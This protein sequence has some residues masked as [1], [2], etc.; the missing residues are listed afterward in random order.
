MPKI[1]LLL[2]FGCLFVVRI[3]RKR[4]S[5]GSWRMSNPSLS[6]PVS[7]DSFITDSPTNGSVSE[8][9][10]AVDAGCSNGFWRQAALVVPSALLLL[11]LGFLARRHVKKLSHRKS[12]VMIAYYAL[13]WTSAISNF[14]WSLLQGWQCSPGMAV[15]WNLLSLFTE[16]GILFLEISIVAFLLQDD[17]ASGLESLAHTFLPSG[18]FVAADILIQ[19]ILTFGFGFPLFVDTAGGGKDWEKWGFPFVH[20]LIVTAIY[21]YILFVHYSKWRDKLPP[22]PSFYN[23]AV[24]MLVFSF[25][26]LLAGGLASVGFGF[27]VWLYNFGVICR[28]ALY[29]PYLYAT[30]LADFFQEE[31][32]LLDNAYY[33]EMK[34]AG[35]FDT[36][37]E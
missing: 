3:D 5:S 12:Y 30:F 2:F 6:L 26:A 9:Y 24:V 13:L 7:P 25:A 16:S 4:F 34:D 35:F 10:D 19:A 17:Y 28:H 31:D 11:Y 27:G 22:R 21:C 36:D 32:W 20:A 8:P 33:A 23:Y 14:A 15:G 29:L 18:S 37:W 1:K